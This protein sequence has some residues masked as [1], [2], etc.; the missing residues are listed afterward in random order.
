M[1]V[2]STIAVRSSRIAGKV[3]ALER[4]AS[5]AVRVAPIITCMLFG[6]RPSYVRRMQL[7]TWCM[8]QRMRCMPLLV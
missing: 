3:K 1:D 4:I 5:G 6:I 7:P 8:Y 2:C